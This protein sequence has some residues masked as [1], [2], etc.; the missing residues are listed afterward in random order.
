MSRRVRT[1]NLL[2]LFKHLGSLKSLKRTGWL[3]RGVPPEQVESVADHTTLTSLIAWLVALDDPGLDADRVLHLALL[4]DLAESIAGDPTP[5]EREEI[6]ARHDSDGLRAFF[7]L[8]HARSTERVATKR[9]SEEAAMEQLTGLMPDAAAAHVAALWREYEEQTTP[10]ARFVKEVD[11]IEAFLQSRDYVDR[12]PD[13]PFEGFR[14]QV[15]EEITH[16]V[17]AAIRD[18]RLSEQQ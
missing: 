1:K 15:Q 4:H 18:E 8:R 3:D 16:P 5:Y 17:L 2:T 14:L 10:E 12:F 7:S 6:P 9:A 13:L 11:M